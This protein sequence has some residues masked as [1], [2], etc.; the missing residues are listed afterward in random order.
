MYPNDIAYDINRLE[1]GDLEFGQLLL[2]AD[3]V[4]V[5]D[6]DQ[7]QQ[8]DLLE[9]LEHGVRRDVGVLQKNFDFK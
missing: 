4:V 6:G 1:V 9:V 7:R 3:E 8:F 5:F 2:V